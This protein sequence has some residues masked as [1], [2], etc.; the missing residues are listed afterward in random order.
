MGYSLEIQKKCQV[1]MQDQS[2]SSVY[3]G[4]TEAA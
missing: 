4:A 1:E 3:L 2:E